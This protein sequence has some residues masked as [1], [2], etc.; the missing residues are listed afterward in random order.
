MAAP[1]RDDEAARL[2]EEVEF[3][4]RLVRWWEEQNGVPASPRMRHALEVAEQKLR[5]HCIAAVA[6]DPQGSG[7]TGGE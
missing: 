4:R 7:G 6:Q 5:R 1:R 3:W 2:V